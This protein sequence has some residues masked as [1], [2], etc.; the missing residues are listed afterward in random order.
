MRGEYFKNLPTIAYNGRQL[1]NIMLRAKLSTDALAASSSYY[2]YEVQDGDTP[3][4]VAHDYY[5]SVAYDWVVLM[6]N[7]MVDPYFEWPLSNRELEEVIAKKY[8]SIATA[9]STIRLYRKAGFPDMTPVTFALSDPADRSGYQPVYAY[10]WEVSR[11]EARRKIQLIDNV[12]IP[13]LDRQIQTVFKQPRR[14]NRI[15]RA[16]P[17]TT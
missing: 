14:A 11:N 10:D 2:P 16:T 3:S 6:S 17:E 5:G 9:M 1:R 8:G 7:T 12:Y 15:Q 13:V 4:N